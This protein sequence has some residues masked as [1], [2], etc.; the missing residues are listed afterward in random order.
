[1]VYASFFAEYF[2]TVNPTDKEHHW[3]ISILE[4]L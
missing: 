2:R 3:F 1:M 4:A